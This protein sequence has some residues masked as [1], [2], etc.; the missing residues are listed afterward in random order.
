MESDPF[1]EV[2]N[3]VTFDSCESVGGPCGTSRSAADLVVHIKT[4]KELCIPIHDQPTSCPMKTTNCLTNERP[5]R[6]MLRPETTDLDEIGGQ[7]EVLERRNVRIGID[8]VTQ[9]I[10]PRQRAVREKLQHDN[11]ERAFP[12]HSPR[13]RPRTKSLRHQLINQP[14]VYRL[15]VCITGFDV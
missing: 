3:L 14:T 9:G 8:M 2:S 10:L 1:R 6:D 4:P 5:A 12:C 15:G 7:P 11:S 13:Q